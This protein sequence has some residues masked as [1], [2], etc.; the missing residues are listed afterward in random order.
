MN[1]PTLEKLLPELESALIGQKFGKIFTLAKLQTAIDFRL[2]DVRYLFVSVEPNNSRIYLIRRR[3][4]DLEKISGT[5]ISF[6]LFLR[7][8]LGSAVLKK[9]VKLE[10]E[11]VLRFEFVAQTELGAVENYA[12]VVQLTGRSANI[13]LLDERGFVLDALRENTGEGQEIAQRY[14]PPTRVSGTGAK[15]DEQ[16]FPVGKHANLSEALD[17][18]YLEKDAEQ[19]FQTRVKA[20]ENKLKQELVKREKL[21]KNLKKDLENHGDADIWKRF[22]DLILANLAH[23]ARID[24]TVLVVDYF[25]ENV[26]TIEI[27]VDANDSLTEAA[28]K[29]FR[30][31]TKARNAKKEVAKRLEILEAELAGLNRQKARLALAIDERDESVIEEF[32]VKIPDKPPTKSRDKHH[33]T[34]T[35]ARRFVSSEN[36]EILVGKG[37]KDNDFLTFRVAK[38]FDLW[39]HAADYP[40][41]HVV[42]RNPNRA[43]IPNATL[44]EAAQLAAFYSHA[45]EQPKVA[46]NY[47]PKKFINKPK[48]AAAGLVSLASF[49]T[50]LVEPKIEADKVTR[51]EGKAAREK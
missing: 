17:E 48:G 39:L 51:D 18:F 40:G 46:V 27:E 41:S 28:E 16:I 50:V 12:L 37:S 49:K 29:F 35:G 26:P 47:T 36:F 20:A 4:K 3:L 13:L 21:V 11:R 31:Y 14:Q 8:R 2:P 19:K 7:K 44:L 25:D 32:A 10:N 42:V 38:S 23:A 1:N 9:I 22:G 30:R 5:P 15:P 45:R 6:A 34:F 24:D 43:E 33:E